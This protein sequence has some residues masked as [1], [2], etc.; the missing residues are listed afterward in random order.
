MKKNS[1]RLN[2]F[3]GEVTL[4]IIHF[5]FGIYSFF[6]M[7]FEKYGIRL[8]FT[9]FWDHENKTSKPENYVKLAIAYQYHPILCIL[10][11]ITI[12]ILSILAIVRTRNEKSKKKMV[13]L[14]T[15][16]LM[17]VLSIIVTIGVIYMYKWE[18]EAEC[19]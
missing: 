17:L 14:I 18:M 11:T 5:Y 10:V 8:Y 15:S 4:F 16:I 7:L 3:I 12:C 6:D 13:I 9:L 19:V 2:S 1:H